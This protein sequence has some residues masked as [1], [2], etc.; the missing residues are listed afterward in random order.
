MHVVADFC[1]VG[2][3]IAGLTL[4]RSLS[5]SGRTV[6]VVE[7]EAIGRGAGYAAAGMLAPLVEARVEERE[8]VGF[9]Y[10]AL[11]NYP[12]FVADLEAE[13]G[14]TVGYRREGTLIVG[15]DRDDTEAIRHQFREHQE[16]GLPVE[17]LSGYECR[18]IEPC[19]APGIPGGI[20]SP[21]DHQIDNRLL[22]AALARS[23]RRRKHVTILE[24]V[25]EGAITETAA[26]AGYVAGDLVVE[27]GHLVLATGAHGELLGSIGLGGAIRPVKGQIIRLDQSAMPLLDHVVRS[28]EMYLVPKHDGTVVLGASSEDRGFDPS[29][30]AGEI[31]ELL[32]AAWECVPGIYELPI[33]ETRVGF[34]P[35]TIDHAPMLGGSGVGNIS[36]ATGYYRHGI[37]FSP[38]AAAILAAYLLRG[39][40]S[41]WL[42]TFSP[43]RFHATS[44]ERLPH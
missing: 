8:V 5:A 13:S 29:I 21:R 20:F 40:E 35:A 34:R 22:L 7:R 1:I 30:T 4:A 39:D 15:V 19:L 25:G 38:H 10:Q 32:R 11:L 17:W 3:G 16:L 12:E 41:E 31:L 44:T 43:G 37:L 6:A 33:V 27:A 18:N 2:G 23:L 36:L 14:M 28:P 24:G 9:G 42:T 26:G